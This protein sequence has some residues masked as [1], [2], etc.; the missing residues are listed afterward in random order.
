MFS[1]KSFATRQTSEMWGTQEDRKD[2]NADTE[3]STHKN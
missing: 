2:L 3:S 1:N